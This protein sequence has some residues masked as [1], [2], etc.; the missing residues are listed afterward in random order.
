MLKTATILANKKN[1]K[2][3]Y[4]AYALFKCIVRIHKTAYQ[5]GQTNYT[6]KLLSQPLAS[7]AMGHWGTCPPRL[8]AIVILGITRFTD[9]DENVQ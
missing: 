2:M 5:G 8:P 1:S 9:S 3:Y 6:T 4:V 7:P